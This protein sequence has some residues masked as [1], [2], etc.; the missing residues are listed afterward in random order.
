MNSKIYSRPRIKLPKVFF[1]NGD[2]KN[3]KRKQKIAKIFIIIVIAFSTIKIVLDAI[4]PIFDTL[5]QDKAKSIATIISNNEATN[6][7]KEHTY[8]E[9]FSI[10]KDNDGNITMI[11]SN[12]ISINEIISDVANKIQNSINERGRD[13]IEIALGSFTG[14]KLFSGRGPGIPIRISSIGNVETDLR[15]EFVAQGINQTLHR[16]Y[17]Q[18]DCEVSI[19]TPYDSI[20]ENISNQVLLVENVI[21]GK[22]PSS[23]YN[24]EG[25]D[26]NSALDIIE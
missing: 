6:V 1:S 18:V 26:Y 8:D 10:E 21:V 14:A 3:L 15:S 19:L 12:I 17:L 11:K 24:L 22:I 20:T 23:Y 16:V 25:I 5:C 2:D 9:L 13:N 7:M 4:L